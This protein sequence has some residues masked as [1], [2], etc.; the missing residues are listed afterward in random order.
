MIWIKCYTLLFFLIC[1]NS[2]GY[3]V[4]IEK[5]LL[6]D[7][8]FQ[9]DKISA[10]LDSLMVFQEKNDG[11]G[12]LRNYKNVNG[13]PPL[14]RKYKINKY[15]Q[16]RDSFGVDRSQG[17]PLYRRG[18]FSVPERYGRDGAYVA[19]ISDSAGCFQVSSA[20][21]AGGMVCS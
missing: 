1:L 21:F 10:F 17:I 12:V 2:V 7:R 13:M 4:K 14:S 3:T 18:N 16:T 19:V 5:R 8:R 20:T 9:W 15:K 6:Y 11:Y